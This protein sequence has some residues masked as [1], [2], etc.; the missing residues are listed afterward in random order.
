[1]N[2]NYGD[3]PGGRGSGARDGERDSERKEMGIERKNW[4]GA[5]GSEIIVQN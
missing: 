3:F 2:D 4:C 1:M 5:K